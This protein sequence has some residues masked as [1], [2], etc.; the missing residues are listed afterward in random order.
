MATSYQENSQPQTRQMDPADTTV[1]LKS[2]KMANYFFALLKF[3]CAFASVLRNY[4]FL[5][6]DKVSSPN[7]ALELNLGLRIS[8]LVP[9]PTTGRN[10]SLL[11]F[12][13]F[14]AL[15]NRTN[16]TQINLVQP[17][18]TKSNHPTTYIPLTGK[19][20]AISNGGKYFFSHLE[21]DFPSLPLRHGKSRPL[22]W[23]STPMTRTIDF[24]RPQQISPG[25]D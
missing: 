21:P 17:Y 8:L 13:Y 2:S 24:T 25:P 18:S 23:S 6:T 5:T 12:C 14:S 10:Q 20:T 19:L 15:A 4:D 16:F 9:L 11:R 1:Y 3:F 22:I 7:S